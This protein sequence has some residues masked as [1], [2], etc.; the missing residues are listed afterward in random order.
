M[1]LCFEG[2]E[3]PLELAGGFISTSNCIF[4]EHLRTFMIIA[5]L[6][7]CFMYFR[8][9]ISGVEEWLLRRVGVGIFTHPSRH[10]KSNGMFCSFFP[11]NSFEFFRKSCFMVPMY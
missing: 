8:I 9:Q 1:I 10:E 7:S 6:W 11:T 2:D 3:E 4:A 5:I